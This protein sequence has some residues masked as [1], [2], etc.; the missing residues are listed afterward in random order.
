MSRT[1]E[2]ER[3]RF[4]EEN[5]EFWEKYNHLAA[6][7]SNAVN[8]NSNEQLLSII[9]LM[10]K[11]QL[12]QI[13][14]HLK[15][16]F[17]HVAIEKGNNQL[18]KPLI[19]CGFNVNIK[20]GCGL[21]PLH[22]AIITGN[23]VMSTFLIERNGRFDGPLFSSMP[24]PKNIADKLHKGD[25]LSAMEDK[26]NESDDENELIS[27]VDRTLAQQAPDHTSKHKDASSSAMTNS[28][29]RTK[30][31]RTKPPRTKSP[32][33]NPPGQNPP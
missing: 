2:G 5:K 7:I 1:L 12:E 13:T 30:S 32:G 9:N 29:S 22:I 20:E 4:R 27:S 18:A 23:Q 6:Q 24:S 19:H 28:G 10:S 15:R 11:E 16:T 26:Q 31:P 8:T 21:T 25:A 3:R 33:Q 14:D 17:L